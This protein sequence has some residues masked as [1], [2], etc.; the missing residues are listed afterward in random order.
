MASRGVT[1]AGTSA[2]MES[3]TGDRVA[4]DAGSAWGSTASDASTTDADPPI[5]GAGCQ[6]SS[7]TPFLSCPDL[8]EP[9]SP[10]EDFELGSYA[11][12]AAQN[13]W[14]EYDDGSSGALSLEV[15]ADGDGSVLYIASSGWTVWGAGI[16]TLLHKPQTCS[17]YCVVDASQFRG[18]RFRA[19]GQ[20]HLRVRLATRQHIPVAEGGD[21]ELSG[22]NCYD[23]AGIDVE[24]TPDWVTHSI[25]FCQLLPEGWG[26]PLANFVLDSADLAALHFRLDNTQP[27]DMWLDDISFYGTAEEGDADRDECR[28]PCPLEAAPST[29]ILTPDVADVA[30][31]EELT[32]HTFEQD[33]TND[34]GT[35]TRRYL[36][37]VPSSAKA[38]TDMPVLFALHGS[39]ANAE[40]M[41]TYQ[42][43]GELNVLA[44]REGFI[45]VY[46]NAAPGAH[47]EA[48]PYVSNSGAWRQAFY[49][50]GQ[51]DDVEYLDLVIQDLQDRS[52]IDGSNAIYLT[53]ISNGGG[54]VLE[55]AK[56]APERFAGIAPF[57]A[58]D[59]W[60]PAPVPD[61]TQTGL[62]R[63]LFAYAPGDPGLPSDYTSILETLPEQWA[64][65][66][67]LSDAAISAPTVTELPD[68][69]I[70]GEDYSGDSPAA[71]TTRDSRVVQLDMTDPGTTAAVRILRYDNA[72]HFWPNPVQDGEAWIL[73]RWGFRNQDL[74][75]SLA[76]WEFLL[77]Q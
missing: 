3:A 17:D 52:V 72:G 54:M 4:T 16:G 8:G 69:A 61:L 43:R 31:S 7:E 75:G 39:G 70:E 44:E 42:T 66:L 62:T 33:P 6:P 77:S 46:G 41:I 37:Y 48:N 49:D 29:A 45:V 63:I 14:F 13:V 22:D 73:D 68:F 58:F 53:G 19:R 11:T 64:L 51:V 47:T 2:E 50:D 55:A 38:A 25:P 34:C 59:G 56:R 21:C 10:I 12:V 67:G 35:L 26:N 30:L 74:D 57:M 60:M 76:I 27:L 36:S 65:A 15:E 5:V 32:L 28:Q 9:A 18:L 40:T 1:D 71:L 23:W 20:G 24:L